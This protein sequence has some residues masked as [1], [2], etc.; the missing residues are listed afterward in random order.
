MIRS[1]EE[2]RKIRELVEKGLSLNRAAK[3]FGIDYANLQKRSAIEGWRL[4]YRGRPRGREYADEVWRAEKAQEQAQR[5]AQQAELLMEARTVIFDTKKAEMV[6]QKVLAQHSSQMKVALSELVVQTAEELRSKEIKPKDRAMAIDALKRVSERLYGWDLE[7]ELAELAGKK[8][9]N[10]AI[11]LRLIAMTPLE[12]R[13][14]GEPKGRGAV[15]SSVE[16]VGELVKEAEGA[17]R[18]EG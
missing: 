8:Q 10:G 9:A 1:K 2:W 4:T 14:L 18:N 13:E 15:E 6:A 5:E 3:Q 12:L 7:R 17:N 16:V 11:N